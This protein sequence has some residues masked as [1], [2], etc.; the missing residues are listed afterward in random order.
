MGLEI[1]PDP[2]LDGRTVAD[3]MVRRPKLLG[4]ATTV[5]EAHDFFADDHVHCALIVAGRKLLAVV[6]RS[7]LRMSLP[8]QA[9]AV[10][11]GSLDARVVRPDAD[12]RTSWDAMTASRRRRLAVIDDNGNCVGLLCLKR[13]GTGFCSDADVEAR[14]AEF[15]DRVSCCADLAD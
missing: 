5:A 11:L 13:S 1:V 8:S 6:E 7:D 4:A 2:R 15:A 14:A 12:L 3:A 10:A 9:P